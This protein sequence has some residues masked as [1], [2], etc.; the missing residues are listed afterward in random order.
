M[1]SEVKNN[2]ESAFRVEKDKDILDQSGHQD[3]ENRIQMRNKGVFFK[4]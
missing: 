1:K 3:R 4:R 2:I